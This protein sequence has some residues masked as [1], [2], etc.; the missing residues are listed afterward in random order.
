MYNNIYISLNITLIYN[1]IMDVKNINFY[2][3]TS[4]R[5]PIRKN[6]NLNNK[7]ILD[8]NVSN[9][10]NNKNIVDQKEKTDVVIKTPVVNADS[11]LDRTSCRMKKS[12]IKPVRNEYVYKTVTQTP[13]GH[14][15]SVPTFIKF[16]SDSKVN[17]FQFKTYNVKVDYITYNSRKKYTYIEA[18]NIYENNQAYYL[19]KFEGE[20]SKVEYKKMVKDVEKMEKWFLK[21]KEPKPTNTE[22]EDYQQDLEDWNARQQFN[23]THL[24][25]HYFDKELLPYTNY[26]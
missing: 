12:D 17:M 3:R 2:N 10:I 19:N 25:N 18:L 6:N 21:F 14:Q 13:A 20:L 23:K 1:K 9:N 26:V 16:T 24:Y 7:S 4:C 5:S 11:M 8:N 15:T 22:D